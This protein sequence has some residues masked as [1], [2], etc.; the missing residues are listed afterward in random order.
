MNDP[1]IIQANFQSILM[2]DA[3]LQYLVFPNLNALDDRVRLLS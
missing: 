1:S 2:P 3:T